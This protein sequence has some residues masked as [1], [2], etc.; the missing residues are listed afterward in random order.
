MEKALAISHK[1]YL[2]KNH[3]IL[4]NISCIY[5]TLGNYNQA[6]H[7][8]Q[9]GLELT[10]KTGYHFT[11]IGLLVNFGYFYDSVAKHNL[12]LDYFQQALIISQET[13]N[14]RTHIPHFWHAVQKDTWII[15]R[16]WANKLNKLIL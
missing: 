12:A 15:I 2:E 9:Q 11:E 3:K 8:W 13:N 16:I 5:Y 4:Q 7:D 6:K 1:D 10:K 14:L